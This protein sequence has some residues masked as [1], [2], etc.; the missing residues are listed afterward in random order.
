M[1]CSVQKMCYQQFFLYSGDKTFCLSANYKVSQI[2]ELCEGSV[3]QCS[4][5][6]LEI[7]G[8]HTLELGGGPPGSTQQLQ[9]AL[10]V[11]FTC[12]TVK[13]TRKWR[14]NGETHVWP[15]ALWSCITGEVWSVRR[16]KLKQW[17]HVQRRPLTLSEPESREAH[18]VYRQALPFKTTTSN[19]SNWDTHPPSSSSSC[20]LTDR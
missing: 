1:R 15:H 14:H 19:S 8:T 18:R 7:K 20:E 3:L 2:K 6:C 16:L 4:E 13:T 5:S 17:V 10:L 12:V 11:L 9:K